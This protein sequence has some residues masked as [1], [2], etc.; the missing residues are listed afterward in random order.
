LRNRQD[1][2][3]A[4]QLAQTE[5]R[6]R[7]RQGILTRGDEAV[8]NQQLKDRLQMARSGINRRGALMS[9]ASNAERI[10]GG[11]EAAQV[12]AGSMV[13]SAYAGAGGFLLGAGIKGFGSQISDFFNQPTTQSMSEGTAAADFM[14]FAPDTGFDF[15]ASPIRYS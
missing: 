1:G 11:L 3:F 10:R 4:S 12:R 9:A 13:D 15:T 14:N 5:R 6:G 7:A 2:S 8:K